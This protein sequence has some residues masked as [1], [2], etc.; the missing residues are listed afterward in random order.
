MTENPRST[1]ILVAEDEPHI[2]TYVQEILS[3]EPDLEVVF[4]ANG[5][6][7]IEAI[8]AEPWD[9]VISDQRMGITDGVEVLG[10]AANVRPGAKRMMMTGFA[11]LPLIASAKNDGGVHRFLAKPFSPTQFRETVGALVAES[12]GAMHRRRAFERA[13]GAGGA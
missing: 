4:V 11:E 5:E 10:T 2:R 9:V 8:V 12:R 6:D 3:D 7:A 1:R 13:T